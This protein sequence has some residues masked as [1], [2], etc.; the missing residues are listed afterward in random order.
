M[1]GWSYNGIGIGN[2]FICSRTYTREGLPSDPHD[3][4]INNRVI[5]FHFGYEGSIQKWDFI[6]KTSYS[7]NYGTY[8]T[9]EVGHTTGRDRVLP[10]YGIFSEMRQFSAYL[11]ANKEL[12]KGLNFGITGAF[13][14]GGLYYDSVG[15][16]VRLSKSF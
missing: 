9:S 16:L 7:L 15:A 1:R 2:P 4:F 10:T 13:D 6:L 3:Y 12:K 5:A 14:S 8:G 11:D